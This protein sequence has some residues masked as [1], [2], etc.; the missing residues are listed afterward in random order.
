[1]LKDARDGREESNVG[2]RWPCCCPELSSGCK[3]LGAGRL[4]GGGQRGE[5][6]ELSETQAG[7]SHTRPQRLGAFGFKVHEEPRGRI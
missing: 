5:G 2:R 7:A 3:V 4:A 1:M 6:R